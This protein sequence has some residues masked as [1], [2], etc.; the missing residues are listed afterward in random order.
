VNKFNCKEES[1]DPPHQLGQEKKCNF[2]GTSG[3]FGGCGGR[4]NEGLLAS[5][6]FQKEMN[7]RK[8]QTLIVGV[9]TANGPTASKGGRQS[10]N[11]L[12]PPSRISRDGGGRSKAL[13]KKYAQQNRN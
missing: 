3:R 13:C 5:I 2:S 10:A 12:E 4:C 8:S 9:M 6:L 11:C 7:L 1:T